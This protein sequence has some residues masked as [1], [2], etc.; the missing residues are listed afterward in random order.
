MNP[1]Q[2]NAGSIAPITAVQFGAHHMF[3]GLLLGKST[4]E[5]SS[6]SR[7]GVATVAGLASALVSTPA[8]L[9]MI[10][11]QKHG[12]SLVA[13]LQQIVAKHG[14]SHLYRGL[15]KAFI[16]PSTTQPD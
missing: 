13:E 3:E 14:L 6:A 11:Q 15:V 8:E 5:S 7:I 12:R 1:V 10:Q 4:N 16:P 9:V 2:V